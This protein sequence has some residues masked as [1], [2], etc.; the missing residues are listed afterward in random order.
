MDYNTLFTFDT[1]LGKI[2]IEEI[3]YMPSLSLNKAWIYKIEIDNRV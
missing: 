2:G 1:T 3:T